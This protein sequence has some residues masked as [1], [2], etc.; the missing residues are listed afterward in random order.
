MGEIE[1]WI[2]NGGC[3]SEGRKLLEST[4]RTAYK[5][6]LLYFVDGAQFKFSVFEHF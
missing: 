3:T 6:G 5:N 2:F 4:V 1:K